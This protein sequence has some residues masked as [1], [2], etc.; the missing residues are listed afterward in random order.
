[1]ETSAR[2]AVLQ[3][4]ADPV[5][6]CVPLG[7]VAA[8]S[9][10][11]R[12][13]SDAVQEDDFWRV[14]VLS[15]WLIK[16]PLMLGFSF[17][18]GARQLLRTL[19]VANPCMAMYLAVEDYLDCDEVAR[20][21]LALMSSEALWFLVAITSGAMPTVDGVFT[22]HCRGAT[23]I[24]YRHTCPA[25]AVTKEYDDSKIQVGGV[26]S[27]SPDREVWFPTSTCSMTRGRFSGEGWQLAADNRNLVMFLERCPIQPFFRSPVPVLPDGVAM[28]RTCARA[29]FNELASEMFLRAV[30]WSPMQPHDII[31]TT[32]LATGFYTVHFVGLPALQLTCSADGWKV[33]DTTASQAAGGAVPTH[34]T[35]VKRLSSPDSASYGL[36]QA[37]VVADF[38]EMFR[39]QLGLD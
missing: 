27:W 31:T 5:L 7:S 12:A 34:A 11:C 17:S 21:H 36:T 28:A 6:R 15:R 37:T 22:Y 23:P 38:N 4:L 2:A 3:R 9:A 20:K 16:D 30:S 10:V 19:T 35:M 33:A 1:M 39:S 13:W 25:V 32:C 8:T 14:H 18:G 26:W 29:R 24:H